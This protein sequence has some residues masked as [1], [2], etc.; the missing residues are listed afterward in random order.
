MPGNPS[1]ISFEMNDKGKLCMVYREDAVTK[2]HDGGLRDMRA[3]RKVVWV[4]PSENP[5]KC[6][7]RL[8]QKYLSLCPDYIKK[9]NFY[10]R[11][12]EKPT[13]KQWYVEQVVGSPNFVKGYRQYYGERRVFW[14]LY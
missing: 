9:S 6:P 3:E 7:V 11:S 12:L 5:I 14:L 1:Q 13:P 2:T 8:T 4:Y 10:M